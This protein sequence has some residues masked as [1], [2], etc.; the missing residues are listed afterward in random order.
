MPPK[1]YGDLNPPARI[2]LGPGPAEV[3]PRVLKALSTPI[4]GHLDPAFLAIMDD[5]VQLLRDTFKTSNRTTIPISG[6]G[7]AGMEAAVCNMVEP[8]DTVVVGVIGVFG[9]RIVEMARR[10]GATVVTIEG[11]WGKPLEPER[12]E[13]TLKGLRKVKLWR[14]SMGRPRPACSSRCG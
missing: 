7:S 13:A 3:H 9:E 5:T 6:T 2:L 4:L 10:Y 8:G 11:E 12:F 1:S 14:W